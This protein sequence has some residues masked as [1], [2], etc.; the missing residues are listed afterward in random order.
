LYGLGLSREELAAVGAGI[1]SDVPFFVYGGTMLVE[2]RGERVT[3]LPEV[4]ETWV[5][6]VVPAVALEQKTA[7]MYARLTESDFTD[8]SRV[9]GRLEFLRENG[10][11]HE[12]HCNVFERYVFEAVEGLE[13]LGDD[14]WLEMLDTFNVAGAGPAIFT[15]MRSRER[16]DETARYAYELARGLPQVGPSEYPP[17]EAFVAGTMGAV[18]A[19]ALD[20]SE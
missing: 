2:G 7:N 16:A 14:V 10:A 3:Q 4:G 15:S 13:A 12:G 9:E 18:E 6:V 20:V 11:L 19:T 17:V 1:G 8:G 5:V